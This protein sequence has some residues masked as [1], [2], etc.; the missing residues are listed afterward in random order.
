MKLYLLKKEKG[1]KY[2]SKAI[3]EKALHFDLK[4]EDEKPVGCSISDTKNYWAIAIGECGID[5]EENN[6]KVKPT[7]VKAFHPNEQ[8][9]LEALSFGTSE[10]YREFLYIWT[11]KEAYFKR[12]G[13]YF[14]QYCVLDDQMLMKPDFQHF[15]EKGLII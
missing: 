1:K 7:I 3:C 14:K 8:K 13:V 15:E 11:A 4:Y 5:I 2:E 6:R 12:Y 10:W 9:Y